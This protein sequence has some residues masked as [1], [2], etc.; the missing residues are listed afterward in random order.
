M[1]KPASELTDEEK[2][3]LYI[4]AGAPVELVTE[5]GR[6]VI[7]TTVPCGVVD[8][9]DGGYIVGIGAKAKLDSVRIDLESVMDNERSE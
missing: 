6:F 3:A 9:G 2:M 5:D 1:N 8:R 4:S 7:R